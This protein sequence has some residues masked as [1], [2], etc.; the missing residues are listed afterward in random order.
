MH[1]SKN[2]WQNHFHVLQAEK[3]KL[4]WPALSGAIVVNIVDNKE[5]EPPFPTTRLLGTVNVS[6]T[7]RTLLIASTAVLE[8]GQIEL[9]LSFENTT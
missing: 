7:A 9:L 5:F 8:L 6:G 2:L 1:R 3:R 4:D